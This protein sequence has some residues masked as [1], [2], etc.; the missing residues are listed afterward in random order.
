MVNLRKKIPRADSKKDMDTLSQDKPYSRYNNFVEQI[1]KE[2][3]IPVEDMQSYA[4]THRNINMVTTFSIKKD[5]YDTFLEVICP[6][7]NYMLT[8]CG[9]D[10]AGIDPINFY[11]HSN[12]YKI[13]H[14]I[15]ILCTNESGRE[16]SSDI[17][18]DIFKTKAGGDN[19]KLCTELYGDLS[20]N[21]DG[22][23]RRKE[24]RY[25]FYRSIK[26]TDYEK[27]TFCAISPDIDITSVKLFMKADIFIK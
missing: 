25:Y 24:E 11:Q 20:Q 17:T 4:V 9:S 26:L 27:L 2:G 19:I 12:L 21:V 8:I 5:T 10:D 1:K 18:I 22:R 15:S 6:S 16:L 3:W 13:P 7:S 23:F 14:S